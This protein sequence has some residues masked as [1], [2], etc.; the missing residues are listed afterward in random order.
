MQVWQLQDLS[1]QAAER[2]MKSGPE[3]RL[4]VMADVA[5]NFPSYARSNRKG[6]ID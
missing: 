5:G 1:L 3:E 2:I 6:L 4:A